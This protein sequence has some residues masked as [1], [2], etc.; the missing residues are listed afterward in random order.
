MLV[1][2]IDDFL[3]VTTD[4][5]QAE[6]FLRVMIDGND[7]Y[8][9]SVNPD[10]TLANFEV[11]LGLQKIPRHHGRSEFPYCGV[12]IDIKTLEVRKD[13]QRKDRFVNNGLTV[14]VARTAGSTFR[15]KV[16]L[17]FKLQM[18]AMLLDPALNSIGRIVAT[19]AEAF[20]ET[21][22][23]MHQYAR[24]MRQYDDMK[25]SAK[26]TCG[27]IAEMV[28][29]AVKLGQK[30]QALVAQK[31]IGDALSTTEM[32]WIASIAFERVIRPKQAGY[33][34]VLHWLQA[35]R[36]RCE[37]RRGM[38]RKLLKRFVEGQDRV[39]HTAVY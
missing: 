12:A 2:L 39:F 4:K 35:C 24:I 31:E 33:Q 20:E 6:Q 1:R 32:F 11:Q 14:N 26:Y 5:Q 30:K 28:K 10:K 16:L 22:M 7:E 27:L 21:A 29:T 9:I 15:R 37:T 8:G 23:K 38:R 34:H 36:K 17:A 25:P 13:W 3:L 18:H 19:Y